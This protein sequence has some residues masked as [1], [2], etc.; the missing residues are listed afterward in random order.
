MRSRRSKST[1]EGDAGSLARASHETS[2]D[3]YVGAIWPQWSLGSDLTDPILLAIEW[4]SRNDEEE[5]F[6]VSL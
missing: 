1:T 2:Q 4:W 3:G 5:P 6:G